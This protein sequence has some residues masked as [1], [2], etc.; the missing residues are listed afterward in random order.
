MKLLAFLL[1]WDQNMPMRRIKLSEEYKL[2]L[3]ARHNSSG[4][5]KEADRIKAVLLRSEGWTVPMISQALRIHQSTII[6]H[7]DDYRQGKLTIASGGSC[8][9]LN[10]EQTANL[11]AHLEKH[12]YQTTQVR[13][14]TGAREWLT[15]LYFSLKT[16]YQ[17]HKICMSPIY[18]LSV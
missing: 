2:K 14:P 17:N 6:R 3:E 15:L 1:L 8:G 5:K 12:T 4:N 9:N 18:Q 13:A 10:L 7:L 16:Y 11:I